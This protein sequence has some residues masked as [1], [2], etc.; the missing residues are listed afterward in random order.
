M[1]DMHNLDDIVVCFGMFDGH[2]GRHN[3]IFDAVHGGYGI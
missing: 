1:W 2:V 3:D